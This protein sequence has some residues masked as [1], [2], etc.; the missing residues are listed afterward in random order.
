MKPAADRPPI[1]LVVLIFTAGLALVTAVAAY[2]YTP[3]GPSGDARPASGMPQAG[4]AR[5][6]G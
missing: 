6:S 2:S 5:G 4:T 1:L 3:E